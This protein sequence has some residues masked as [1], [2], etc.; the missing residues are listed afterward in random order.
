MQENKEDMPLENM[1][2]IIEEITV[3]MA[4]QMKREQ[5]QK[6]RNYKSLNKSAKKGQIL[7][8][9]SSLMEQFPICELAQNLQ[10]DKLVYNRGIGGTRT[11]DFLREIDTVLLDLAPSKVFIN[12]GTNDMSK[13]PY[14]EKWMDCLFKNYE[15]ILSILKKRIAG[16]KRICYGL[17]SG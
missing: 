13:H 12:I 5:Q 14:G 7:F 2:K 6:V 16:D 8:T 17:L 15:K 10:L 9:G 3:Y 11:E 1:Q 4:N